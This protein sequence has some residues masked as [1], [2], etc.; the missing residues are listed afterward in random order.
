MGKIVVFDLDGTISFCEHRLHYIA[1]DKRDWQSFYKACVD[2]V[3]NDP[4]ILVLRALHSMGFKVIIISGRSDE[5]RME[6][7]TWLTEHAV[8]CEGLY[9]RPDKDYT[10]DH[11]LKLRLMKD[12]Q[13]EIG[14]TDHDVVCIFDD[15]QKVVDM[16]RKNGFTCFQVADGDY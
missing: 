8:P 4:V 14:F 3:P 12:A 13:Q 2:D 11:E 7:L 9:M 6:T 16:W 15:R 5:V 10:P 1:G